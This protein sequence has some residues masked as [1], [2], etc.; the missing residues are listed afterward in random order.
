MTSPPRG[1]RI[2]TADDRAHADHP[3]FGGFAAPRSPVTLPD[4]ERLKQTAGLTP[5]DESELRTAAAVLRP[6][7]GE[8]V[9]TWRREIARFGHLSAYSAG[10]DGAANAAYA[11]ATHPRF[12]RWVIEACEGPYDQAWLDYQHEIGLRHTRERKNRTD[13]VDNLEDHI[14]LR[15]LL[16]FTPVVLLTTRGFLARGEH[17]AAAVQR[18]HDAW[19][20]AVL[21][22]VTLWTRAYVDAEDW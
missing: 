12:A 16:A 8:M 6:S 2:I 15:Y 20:K 11:A 4:L 21:L 9:D 5:D 7:A 14:P 22:H 18:M 3:R 19:I 17:D 10:A 1:G 13:A